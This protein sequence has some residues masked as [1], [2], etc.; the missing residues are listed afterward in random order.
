MPKNKVT[1]VGFDSAVFTKDQ[2]DTIQNQSIELQKWVSK[3][4][5]SSESIELD[6]AEEL[7]EEYPDQVFTLGFEPAFADGYSLRYGLIPG[8]DEDEDEFFFA[9]VPWDESYPYPYTIIDFQ[10]SL[11]GGSGVRPNSGET[12]SNCSNGELSVNIF[13]DESWNVTAEFQGE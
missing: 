6:E 1:L 13:W 7:Q 11:C 9:A 3:Y 4:Q 5:I 2:F 10:C 8:I 12:C